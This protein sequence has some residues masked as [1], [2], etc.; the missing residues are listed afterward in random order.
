MFSLTKRALVLGLLA[1]LAAPAAFAQT[2][3]T[4]QGAG[5]ADAQA[6]D[7]AC[8]ADAA[9]AQCGSEKVGSG[10]MKCLGAYRKANPSF[11]LSEGCHE[12]M[13][14]LHADHKGMGGRRGMMGGQNGAP[15]TAPAPS[16]AGQ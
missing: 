11:K 8:T 9:T 1:T 6:V 2:A 5:S 7:Q 16:G 4:G 13:E 3:P 14:K 10:L 12:A 15:V